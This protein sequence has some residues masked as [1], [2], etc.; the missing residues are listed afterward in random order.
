V[1]KNRARYKG[2]AD[3]VMM[4]GGSGGRGRKVG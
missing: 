3:N 4:V 1:I 2:V